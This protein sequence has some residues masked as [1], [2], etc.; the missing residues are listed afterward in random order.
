LQRHIGRL[1][2]RLCRKDTPIPAITDG[3]IMVTN[4][5]RPHDTARIM[6]TLPQ[7]LIAD[8]LAVPMDAFV[9]ALVSDIA[10][11]EQAMR[12]TRPTDLHTE[13]ALHAALIGGNAILDAVRIK[14]RGPER[15]EN[16]SARLV[17]EW[18]PR[19]SF[20]ESF[21]A[22]HPGSAAHAPP[23]R[24]LG[25]AWA[26]T[27]ISAKGV[28][29]ERGN[30]KPLELGV[31]ALVGLDWA[32]YHGEPM[33]GFIRWIKESKPGEQRMGIAFFGQDYKLFRGSLLGGR[34]EDAERSEHRSWPVL[35]KPGKRFHTAIFP[36]NKIFR[37]MAFMLSQKA[38]TGYFKVAEVTKTGPNYC[39]CKVVP[40]GP[41]ESGR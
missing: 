11:A 1:K 17:L 20:V 39:I 33:L 6:A 37:S 15:Q 25:H 35:L 16:A 18:N 27:N 22:M 41:E 10:R 30:G 21:A 31:D 36:E 7:P 14:P 40:A 29:L 2:P 4:L 9:E 26:V 13:E 19:Q 34:T 32:P 5:A 23:A 12:N 3:A 24:D 28:G 38:K 8:C